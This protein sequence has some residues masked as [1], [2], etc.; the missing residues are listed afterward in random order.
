MAGDVWLVTC[1]AGDTRVLRFLGRWISPGW[2][3]PV[4]PHPA[5]RPL[6]VGP[7]HPASLP[8]SR[9]RAQAPCRPPPGSP[10][11]PRAGLGSR[12]DTIGKER[13]QE[14]STQTTGPRPASLSVCPAS[15]SAEPGGGWARRCRGQTAAGRAAAGGVVGLPRPSAPPPWLCEVRHGPRGR[16]LLPGVTTAGG[17]RCAATGL[18]LSRDQ[19][20]VG[21][22]LAGTF[23]NS[24]GGKGRPRGS[25]RWTF[26]HRSVYWLCAGDL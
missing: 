9:T 12:E 5:L 16:A 17:P 14:K 2:G 4:Q 10:G 20:L 3:C 15:S 21:T 25:A 13:K 1:V 24:V 11:P 26:L 23:R 22:A 8:P 19:G 7:P 18:V 6:V